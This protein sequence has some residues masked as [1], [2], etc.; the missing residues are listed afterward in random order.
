MGGRAI[1]EN[2]NVWENLAYHRV[3]FKKKKKIAEIAGCKRDLHNP[4][5]HFCKAGLKTSVSCWR[6]TVYCFGGVLGKHIQML[7][8]IPEPLYFSSYTSYHPYL[9]EI[10]LCMNF[11]LRAAFHLWRA[12]FK[13]TEFT[14]LLDPNLSTLVW[15]QVPLNSTELASKYFCL[16]LNCKWNKLILLK[17]D[18]ILKVQCYFPTQRQFLRNRFP[19]NHWDLLLSKYFKTEANKIFISFSWSHSHL[20]W[21]IMPFTCGVLFGSSC[22]DED[23]GCFAQ[24]SFV[25]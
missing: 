21:K 4:L 17:S 23:G 25:W 1:F 3:F 18:S 19:W 15:A 6:E 13:S 9:S 22:S 24:P 11:V 5:G 8:Y 16:G 14:D 20:L 12:K 2:K 7:I 10:F